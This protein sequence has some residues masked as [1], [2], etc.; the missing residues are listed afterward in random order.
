M[1]FSS[2][3]NPKC[4][5][6]EA[7]VFCLIAGSILNSVLF[8]LALAGSIDTLCHAQGWPRAL[9]IACQNHNLELEVAVSYRQT[10]LVRASGYLKM[11]FHY[12][13]FTTRS[14]EGG[15]RSVNCASQTD[16]AHTVRPTLPIQ[17]DRPCLCKDGIS[18]S[19]MLHHKES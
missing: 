3:L 1:P 14:L 19:C 16:L 2:A 8:L 13:C 18:S 12:A 9:V 15:R 4:F 6:T 7:M 10:D 11:A 5:Q 17:S